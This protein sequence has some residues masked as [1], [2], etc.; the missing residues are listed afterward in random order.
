MNKTIVYYTANREDPAFEQKVIDQINKVKGDIPVISVSQKP[1]DFG[2]NI[3]VGDVG[4]TYLNAFRQLQIGCEEA[5]T[6]YVIMSESDCWYPLSGYFDFN[7][8][9]PSVIY[10]YDSVYVIRSGGT[11]FYGKR[12]THG[13]IVYGRKFLLELLNESFRN[14]PQWSR[15]K[16]G[17]PFY[18]ETHK[19]VHFNGDPIVSVKTGKGF[20]KWTRTD[21]APVKEIPYWGTAKEFNEHCRLD[22]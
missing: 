13:S 4:Q 1:L 17:F 21:S 14:L 22:T 5:R 12:Q 6:E 2:M 20:Q 19:F 9:D 10:T 16:I 7:F 15:E 3:C 8:T 18:N 11:H